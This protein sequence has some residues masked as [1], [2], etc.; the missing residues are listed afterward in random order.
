MT[1]KT[2]APQQQRS[3]ETLAR[4]L[5]ATI[6]TLDRHGL[7]GATIPRIAATAGVAPASVYR[8]FTDRDALFQ[9]ALLAALEESAAANRTRLRIDSFKKKSLEG[10][11]SALIA[12]FVKQYQTHPGLLRALIRFIESDSDE[13]F[14]EK[15]VALISGNFEMLT[16]LILKFRQEIAH[17]NPRRAVIFGLLTVVTAIE[18][19][20]L[21]LISMWHRLLPISDRELRKELTRCFLAYLRGS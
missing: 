17:P 18:E 8:R 4:L 6:A 15:A 13:G 5:R 14:R 10:V 1:S 16:D 20:A 12:A 21:G 7:A 11:A 2:L 9:T 3:R 19:R